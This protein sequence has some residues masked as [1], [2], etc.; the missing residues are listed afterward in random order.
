LR[1]IVDA[2]AE[3][4]LH[5]SEHG[6]DVSAYHDLKL[7]LLVDLFGCDLATREAELAGTFVHRVLPGFD[8]RYE[9]QPSD[10]TL[11]RDCIRTLNQTATPF[12]YGVLMEG[13][14]SKIER[15][16]W[17]RFG[18][19]LLE[20]RRVLNDT[21]AAVAETILA[22]LFPEITSKRHTWGE[23]TT[24]GLPESAPDPLDYY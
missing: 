8:D 16:M 21:I 6:D 4:Q 18:E 20:Q 22:D 14:P 23:L 12:H 11:F 9:I 2:F 17:E 7:A 1:D 24:R 13:M 15:E 5:H 3:Q 10:V 19:R